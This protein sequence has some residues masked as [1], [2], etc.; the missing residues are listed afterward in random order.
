MIKRR[1]L[2]MTVGMTAALL[3]AGCGSNE[4]VTSD[5]NMS[6][7]EAV[8]YTITGIEPGAG[9][10]GLAHNALE[11]YENLEGWELA[12]SS[13]A[14]MMTL[15]GEAI[16]NEE[17]IIVTGWAPHYKFTQYDLKF[18]EDPKGSLGD[19]ESIHTIARTGFKEEMPNAYQIIDAFEWDVEDMESVMY[20]AQSSSFEDASMNWIE[21]NQDKVDSWLEGA[22]PGNGEEIDIV[23]SPW[24][25][26][27]ASS[28]VI[29]MVLEQQGFDVT[30]SDVDPAVLFEAIANGEAD[31]SLA[32]WL[33]VTHE[34]FY[35]E[36]K[37]DIVDMGPNLTG[38]QN[39]FV[40]PAYMDID[41]IEDLE[42][43]E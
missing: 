10:T 7:S 38:A 34:A 17:P 43:K 35:E 41:S 19:I 9:L 37:E 26:E 25:T 5:E 20:E 8:D 24:D 40:V 28:Q 23:S 22:E 12:E 29:K 31:V 21:A 27:R 36:H 32:P 15:L 11:E 2:G 13:T 42:P 14:G 33:P 6:I 1:F 16:E 39:G 30:V 18:I 4:E 3:L